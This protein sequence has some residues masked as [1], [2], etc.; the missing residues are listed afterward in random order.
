VDRTATF[1]SGPG[2]YTDT[3][4]VARVDRDGTLAG[5]CMDQLPPSAGGS[6]THVS[7][8]GKIRRNQVRFPAACFGQTYEPDG[9]VRGDTIAGQF[10]TPQGVG[11]F[12]L[13]R[14]G[15]Q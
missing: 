3:L 11:S 15:R 6:V 1:G 12:Q 5:S 7:L 2:S 10:I 9:T 13:K 14:V 8:T 4:T